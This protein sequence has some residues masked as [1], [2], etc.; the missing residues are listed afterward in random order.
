LREAEILHP[1]DFML[2]L[3]LEMRVLVRRT[4]VVL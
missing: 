4:T 2:A 1:F 3:L